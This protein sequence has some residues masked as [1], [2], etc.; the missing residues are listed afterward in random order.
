ME[1]QLPHTLS[2]MVVA[3]ADLSVSPIMSPG[4]PQIFDHS[5][6]LFASSDSSPSEVF[7]LKS[8]L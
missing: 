5:F 1:K 4:T 6:Q 2:A 3:V 7:L 8:A